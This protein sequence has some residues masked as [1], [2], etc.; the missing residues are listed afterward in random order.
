MTLFF[1][2]VGG[3]PVIPFYSNFTN[4]VPWAPPAFMADRLVPAAAETLW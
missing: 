4:S 1:A 2:K 3:N